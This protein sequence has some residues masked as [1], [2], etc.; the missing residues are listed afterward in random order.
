MVLRMQIEIRDEDV[1]P[2]RRLA[3]Q[4]HRSVREQ[5]GFLLAQKIAEAVGDLPHKEV[6]VAKV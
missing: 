3:W 6:E 4:D 5:A 1:E 2:L